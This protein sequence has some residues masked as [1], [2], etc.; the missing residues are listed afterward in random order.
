MSKMILRTAAPVALAVLVSGCSFLGGSKPPPFLLRLTPESAIAANQ[1]RSAPADEAITVIPPVSP[2]ELRTNRIPV[3]S[4][5]TQLTYL[6]DAQ[7]VES[8]SVLIARLISETISARNNRVVLD[9]AQFTLDPGTRLTGQLQT[10][11]ID[12]TSREAILI[13]DAAI[14]R[15]A[16]RVETRRFE[17]RAPVAA[18]DAASAGSALNQVA[19][20]IARDVAAWVG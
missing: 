3:R 13:Y 5:E 15:G 19:N 11:G 17:A 9:A 16:D 1:S 2:M 14:S 4:G 6:K 10:F 18:V 12:A 20:Q 8:P 7:W